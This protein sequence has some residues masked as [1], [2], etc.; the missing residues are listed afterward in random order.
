[1]CTHTHVL[2]HVSIVDTFGQRELWPQPVLAKCNPGW[3]EVLASGSL[4]SA[5]L[6]R[7]VSLKQ[8]LGTVTPHLLMGRPTREGRTAEWSFFLELG[9]GDREQDRA[10]AVDASPLG[11]RH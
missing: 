10:V 5:F 9:W 8:Y 11:P 1:M 7:L 6:H 4:G 2:T 3:A